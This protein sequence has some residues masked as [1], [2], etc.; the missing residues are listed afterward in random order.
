MEDSGFSPHV[1]RSRRAM[2]KIATWN[3][4]SLR[5]RLAHVLDW[6]ARESPD[7]V[8]L[9]ETKTQDPQFPSAELEAAGYTSLFAGQKAYNGVAVLSKSPGTLI[10]A[11]LPA[12]DDPQRRV[13]AARYGDLTLLNLYVPNGNSVGSDKYAY[14]LEWLAALA[15]YIKSLID[16]QAK[17]VVV[18]DFNIAPQDIDVHDPTAWQGKILVSEAERERLQALFALGLQDCFRA[19][20]PLESGFSWWDYRAGSFRR[21][22][23]MRIDLILAS[24]AMTATLQACF[25]DKSPRGWEKPSDHTPVVA[26]FDV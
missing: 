12:I 6:L 13:L 7:L 16:E 22:H 14:K 15:D 2:L 17:L 21:D 10:T 8:A 26:K 20:Q 25:V 11:D 19:S 1:P 23:G 5:A 4:N 18:G 3:V 24:E 9:Q